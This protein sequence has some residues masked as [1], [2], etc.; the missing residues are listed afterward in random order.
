MR[1]LRIFGSIVEVVIPK[2]E[3]GNKF[4]KKTW[5]GI[6]VGYASGDAYR[7]FL[8]TQGRVFV[9]KDVIFFEELYRQ[10]VSNIEQ[11]SE[12]ILETEESVTTTMCR[13]MVLKLILIETHQT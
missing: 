7:I 5:Y 10:I 9:T 2:I 3:K 4:Y 8:R 11:E 12:Q 6:H 13:K 1:S